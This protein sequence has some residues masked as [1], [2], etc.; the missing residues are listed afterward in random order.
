MYLAANPLDVFNPLNRCFFTSL[1]I[2]FAGG[3]LVI[4]QCPGAFVTTPRD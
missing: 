4:K 3:Q 2:A 1:D